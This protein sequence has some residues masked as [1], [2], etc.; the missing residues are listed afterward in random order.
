MFSHEAQ[1]GGV[2]ESSNAEL[3]FDKIILSISGC[4]IQQNNITN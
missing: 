1:I 4:I 2:G 3:C